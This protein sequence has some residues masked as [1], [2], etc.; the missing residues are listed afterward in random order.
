M[1]RATRDQLELEGARIEEET[2]PAHVEDLSVLGL[3]ELDVAACGTGRYVKAVIQPPA[4]RI[5]H[6]LTSFIAGKAGVDDFANIGLAV[7]VGV[8]EVKNVRH[9]P[10][11][12]AAIPAR[13][14]DGRIDVVREDR[15][16][17]VEI[18]RAS[19]RE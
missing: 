8:L 4:E 16:L 17:V 15:D 18:G 11:E 7:A 12:E 2:L 1:L 6:R 9:R 5:E 19:C 13:Q 3:G 14:R 10:D